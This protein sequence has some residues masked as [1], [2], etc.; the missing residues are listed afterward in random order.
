M[1]PAEGSR[2]RTE[3]KVPA[4]AEAQ[5]CWTGADN[6][7]QEGA[8]AGG[9]CNPYGTWRLNVGTNELLLNNAFIKYFSLLV[10]WNGSDVGEVESA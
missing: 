8:I 1:K 2:E 9:E 4:I 10:V 6:F 7:N 3:E 5:P